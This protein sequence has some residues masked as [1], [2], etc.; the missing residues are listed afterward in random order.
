MNTPRLSTAD[1]LPKNMS[2]SGVIL[3]SR[4]CFLSQN[5]MADR[6]TVQTKDSHSAHG[7]EPLIPFGLIASQRFRRL[8]CSAPPAAPARVASTFPRAPL[9]FSPTAPAVGLH[10]LSTCAPLPVFRFSSGKLFRSSGRH[11]DLHL[12]RPAQA[13][14]NQSGSETPSRIIRVRHSPVHVVCGRYSTG[15]HLDLCTAV[16]PPYVPLSIHSKAISGDRR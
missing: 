7:H 3:F 8:K 13:P 12:N 10:R 1:P 15:S 9:D 2:P 16:K 14:D 11:S 6:V 4:F 5:F